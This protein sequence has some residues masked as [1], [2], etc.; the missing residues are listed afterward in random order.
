M[1]EFRLLHIT[2]IVGGICK[3]LYSIMPG[4]SWY[5]MWLLFC[6]WI[7]FSACAWVPVSKTTGKKKGVAALFTVAMFLVLCICFFAVKTF[8][9]Q[10]TTVTIILA[11]AAILLFYDD[12]YVLSVIFYVLSFSLRMKAAVMMM[13]LL[14]MI[15]AVKIFSEK[16]KCIGALISMAVCFLVI[17]G[18]ETVS[19]SPKEWKDFKVYNTARENIVDYNGY[20]DYEEYEEVYSEYGISNAAYEAARTGYLLLFDNGFTSESMT[21]LAELSP[22]HEGTRN[23]FRM[24]SDFIDRHLKSYDDRPINI[25]VFT[26]YLTVFVLILVHKNKQALWYLLALGAGRMAIWAYLIY[27]DRIPIRISHGVY[28]AEAIM[29]VAMIYRERLWEFKNNKLSIVAVSVISVAIIGISAKWGI[30]YTESYVG[31]SHAR[32]GFT[33]SYREMREFFAKEEDSLFLLDTNSFLY[34]CEPLVT[35]NPE[36][37]VNFAYLGCWTA[38]SPWNRQIAE[39]NGFTDYETCFEQK[40]NVYFVFMNTAVTGSEYLEDYFEKVHPDVRITEN[41]RYMTRE[42][43]EFIFLKAEKQ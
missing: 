6:L 20:P 8:F 41:S 35:K 3:L 13:P 29:L 39:Y 38:N 4:Y 5:G 31:Y 18:I 1:P 32:M 40:D 23:V 12:R 22:K 21:A 17:F 27:I 24:L 15:A 25:L 43:L 28:I 33:N 14:L 2:V 42:G 30:K 9:V 19:Y 16:K 10:Y 11:A 7:S 34:F 36:A 37:K 26:L